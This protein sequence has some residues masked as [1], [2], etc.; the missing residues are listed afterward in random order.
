MIG[1]D[2]DT[3]GQ[4]DVIVDFGSNYGVYARMNDSTW[5]QLHSVSPGLMTAGHIN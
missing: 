3:N 5:Q 4:D 1:S 2:L